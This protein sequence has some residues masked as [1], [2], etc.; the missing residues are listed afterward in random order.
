MDA[1]EKIFRR[2]EKI[3][4]ERFRLLRNRETGCDIGSC[5]LIQRA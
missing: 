1:I 3:E 2:I 4:T 5:R